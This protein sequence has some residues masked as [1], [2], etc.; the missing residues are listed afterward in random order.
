MQEPCDHNDE[1]ERKKSS[2]ISLT[3]HVKSKRSRERSWGQK[4]SVIFL[5]MFDMFLNA[6]THQK[7]YDL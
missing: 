3:Y 5:A 1:A 4:A 2:Y 6:G 7:Y